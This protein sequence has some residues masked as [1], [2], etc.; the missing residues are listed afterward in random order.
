MDFTEILVDSW[1]YIKCGIIANSTRWMQLIVAVLFLGI[2]FNGYL[3]RVYRGITP[4]PEVDGW[5][6]LFI[7]GLKVLVITIIYIL[8]LLL[9]LILVL[10]LMILASPGGNIGDPGIAGGFF[11]SLFTLLYYLM[12]FVIAAI[13][14]VAYIRFART[15]LFFE[16]FNFGAILE[17]IGRIGWLNY[18][19][20][21]VFIAL[22]IGV[23]L[24]MVLFLFLFILFFALVL[25]NS[26][27]VVVV[28][29]LA[30]L[31]LLALIII[32]LVSVFQARYL[33]RVYNF[34]GE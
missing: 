1:D 32:P 16:A 3:L 26:N 7:D 13:L 33:T 15:G 6:T 23:P 30:F 22:L 2:P 19:V 34:S 12:E 18:V 17:T 14:P 31:A 4:A 20:A 9:I 24:T 11:E 28:G 25:F 8:P 5:G 29:I 10:G 27:I 21:V